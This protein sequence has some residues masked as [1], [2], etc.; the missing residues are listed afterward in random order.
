MI[1]NKE[2]IKTRITNYSITIFTF[3]LSGL[4]VFFFIYRILMFSSA[5]TAS[6][7]IIASQKIIE[8][9]ETGEYKYKNNEFKYYEEI[10]NSEEKKKNLLSQIDELNFY[11]IFIPLIIFFLLF[12]VKG[13]ANV[14][15]K[16]KPLIDYSKI[17]LLSKDKIKWY[18]GKVSF[19]YG[20]IHKRIVLGT[21]Y[22]FANAD[23]KKFIIEHELSHLRYRD[24]IFKN[25]L[26]NLRKFFLPIFY[27]L[28]WFYSFQ[29]G[30]LKTVF[31]YIQDTTNWKP[32]SQQIILMLIYIFY[33]ILY[34]VILRI[35]LIK[36]TKWFSF[37]KEF[38]ADKFASLKTNYIPNFYSKMDKN[39]PSGEDRSMFLKG[40]KNILDI[41]PFLFFTTILFNLQPDIF[42]IYFF[43]LVLCSF[44]IFYFLELFYFK[45]CFLKLKGFLY[46]VFLT[47]FFSGLNT[48]LVFLHSKNHNYNFDSSVNALVVFFNIFILFTSLIFYIVQVIRNK[49]NKINES[50]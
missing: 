34:L 25:Y 13:W 24:S 38:L 1:D 16:V 6:A 18:I 35:A 23:T 26:I 2:Y 36:F 8:K 5:N 30:F 15:S 11:F 4:F 33:P 7:N 10:N 41:F 27:I 12:W 42:N 47:I 32:T 31:Y 3:L 49:S 9:N 45:L 50:I 48:F 37:A 29:I 28:Y 44:I 22:F 17:D 20:F 39:H 40:K 46:I 14:K 43:L 19:S 21:D